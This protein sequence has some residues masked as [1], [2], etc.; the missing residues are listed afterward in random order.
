MARTRDGHD[1][2][3]RVITIKNEGH[4]HLSILRKVAT[5]PSTL[6]SNNHVLPMF[7][8]FHFHDVAFGIFPKVGWMVSEAYNCWAKNS[9]GDIVDMLMQALEVRPN[10]PCRPGVSFMVATPGSRVHS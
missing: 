8:E 3:I 6:L 5:G 7:A 2:A 9:V 4:K 1:V 10:M